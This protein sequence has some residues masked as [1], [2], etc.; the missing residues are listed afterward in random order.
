MAIYH[1]YKYSELSSYQ[2]LRWNSV[3]FC[4]NEESIFAANEYVTNLTVL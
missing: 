3:S 2:I 4:P 1:V